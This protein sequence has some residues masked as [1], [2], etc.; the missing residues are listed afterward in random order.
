MLGPSSFSN[1]EAARRNGAATNGAAAGSGGAP[2]GHPAQPSEGGEEVSLQDVLGVLFKTKWLILACFALLLALTAVYTLIKAPEYEASSSILINNQSSTPQLGEMLGLQQKA[3][4]VNEVEILK[5]R[6]IA[7][8]VAAELMDQQY[9]PGTHKKLS[10]LKTAPDTVLTERMVAER[11]PG[12]VQIS[13]LASEADL[14]NIEAVSTMPKEAALIADLYA[15]EYAE[16][17]RAISSRRARTSR[18]FLEGAVSNF[19]TNLRRQESDLQ[20]FLSEQQVM[21]P[22]VE[23][24]Q[25]LKQVS[26][27]EKQRLEAQLQR[28]QAQTRLQQLQAQLDSIQP[29]L[30]SEITNN[31]AMQYSALQQQIT[32]LQ[33]ELNGL[34]AANPDLR[35]DPTPRIIQLRR[36]IDNLREQV[37]ERAEKLSRDAIS[38]SGI[39]VSG[40]P[41]GKLVR[42]QAL[43]E[44][45]LV[46][47]LNLQAARASLNAIGKEMR[48]YERKMADL[49]QQEIV[50]NRLER[51]LRTSSS[52]Y[53]DLQKKLYDARIA[54]QSEMGKVQ[55][56]DEARVPMQPVRPRAALNLML[57]GILGLFLGVGVAF[58]R[59]MLDNKVRTPEDLRRHGHSVLGT[60]PDMQTVVN[61]DFDG[62]DYVD[63][64]GHKYST[65]LISLLNPLSP[66]SE[67]YRHLRTNLQFSR[68]DSDVRTVMVTSAGPGEGK[69]V[70]AANLAVTMA[71]PGGA[72]STWTPTFAG[73]AGT[74]YSAARVNPDW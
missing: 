45:A 51:S 66:I 42:V 33:T 17:D 18:E 44:E 56:I 21:A 48:R 49:P 67:S 69:S 3:N 73:P 37:S 41:G 23:A 7:G 10:I 38:G 71:S 22:N 34:Y 65:R 74:G 5:S 46:N 64:D 13:S 72:R 1:G 28:G 9:A 30:A 14:V 2:G 70:T 26:E 25:L 20:S 8:R 39:G 53:E 54:E 31:D 61:S 35:E 63:V 43:S 60:V 16:Y 15:S 62:R 40:A 29:G 50:L 68:P 59:N 32:A 6:T 57:G 36:K 27:L 55:I 24:E 47:K 52:V 12:R 4:V 11:L 19:E 58:V